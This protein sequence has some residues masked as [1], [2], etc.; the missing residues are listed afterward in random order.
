MGMPER[1][2]TPPVSDFMTVTP[3]SRNQQSGQRVGAEPWSLFQLIPLFT[4]G[5][6]CLQG[7]FWISLILMKSKT[8][9]MSQMPFYAL[10]WSC[11]LTENVSSYLKSGLCVFTVSWGCESPLVS[12]MYV[13]EKFLICN[14][15]FTSDA[16]CPWH[17]VPAP[18]MLDTKC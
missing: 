7:V 17:V 18:Q 1:E 2:V 3:V 16:R 12:L 10:C 6:I 14:I 11:T 9:E 5:L 15:V 13:L 4:R 8:V